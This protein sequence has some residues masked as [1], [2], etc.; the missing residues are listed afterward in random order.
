MDGGT[1]YVYFSVDIPPDPDVEDDAGGG[2]AG[3]ATSK[4]GTLIERVTCDERPYMFISYMREAMSCDLANPYGE[5]AC[6]DDV[7][8][9]DEEL[10]IE[11]LGIVD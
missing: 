2:Y 7:Y 9:R 1:N 8:D 10:D 11:R 3:L 5:A 6:E 4:E